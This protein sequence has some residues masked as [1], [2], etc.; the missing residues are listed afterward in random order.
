MKKL[1]NGYALIYLNSFPN[2]SIYKEE[3]GPLK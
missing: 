1:F 2:V 3:N